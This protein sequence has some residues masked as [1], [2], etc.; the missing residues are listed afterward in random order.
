MAANGK[1]KEWITNASEGYGVPYRNNRCRC[2]RYWL[3]NNQQ[4]GRSLQDLE[5]AR[6]G[7][8][9]QCTPICFVLLWV[10]IAYIHAICSLFFST[11]IH[12]NINGHIAAPIQQLRGLLQGDPLSP[13]LFNLPLEPFYVLLLV[14]SIFKASYLGTIHHLHMPQ[15][16]QGWQQVWNP[17]FFADPDLPSLYECCFRLAFLVQ[18]NINNNKRFFVHTSSKRYGAHIGIP[19]ITI[20]PFF[21]L[22]CQL[23]LATCFSRYVFRID[24]PPTVF[25]FPSLM[26][27]LSPFCNCCGY[28]T[29]WYEVAFQ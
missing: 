24:I 23:T 7:F 12:I 15:K 22:K 20:T 11:S 27:P 18:P 3:G 2:I 5:R 19:Y 8:I 29:M 4:R 16:D 25:R 26:Y 17:I 10:S 14:T 9:D 13:I 28:V 21:Q 6:K 1:V